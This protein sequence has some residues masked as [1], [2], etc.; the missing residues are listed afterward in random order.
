LTTLAMMLRVISIVL[1][2]HTDL[3]CKWDYKVEGLSKANDH[4]IVR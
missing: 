4:K 3:R 2:T 1:T